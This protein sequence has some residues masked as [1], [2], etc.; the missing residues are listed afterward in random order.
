VAAISSLATCVYQRAQGPTRVLVVS[1]A[2]TRTFTSRDTVADARL[3]Q[4]IDEVQALQQIELRVGG[5]SSGGGHTRADTLAKLVGSFRDEPR[6]VA[7]SLVDSAWSLPGRTKGYLLASLT[8]IA[9]VQCPAAAI[10]TGAY[11][12]AR[13]RFTDLKTVARA[14]PTIVSLERAVSDREVADVNRAQF[15]TQENNLLIIPISASPGQYMLRFGV[16]LTDSLNTMY[17]KFFQTGC[18]LRVSA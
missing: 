8:S 18:P 6:L 3:K 12:L 11:V 17:P 13:F 4:L 7:N 2:T 5:A 10:R 15:Q 16:F 9:T 1:D 14:T